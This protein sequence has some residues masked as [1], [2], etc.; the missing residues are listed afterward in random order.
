M[1]ESFVKPFMH[2][3]VNVRKSEL[4]VKQILLDLLHQW[5]IL[6]MKLIL[7]FD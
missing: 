4:F 2:K 6:R 1:N 3:F 7:I 5:E